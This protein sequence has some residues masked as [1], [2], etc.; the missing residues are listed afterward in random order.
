MFYG[1][2]QLTREI[3][4][5]RDGT[6]L[7]FGGRQLGKTALLRHVE[8]RVSDP[9]LRRFAW[10]IDLKDRGYVPDA[11]PAKDPGDILEVLRDRFRQDDILGDDTSGHSQEQMR[12]E[13]LDAFE[14]DRDLQVLAMFDESDAF[15]QSDWSSGSAVVE[16][17]RALM[18]NTGNRFK[19]VFAGLHNVQRF[20]NRPNNPFPNLGLQ[21]QQS[22]ERWDRPPQGPRGQKS[23]RATLQPVG[24]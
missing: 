15:L 23:R 4:A 2:E 10:F 9:G 19:V 7:I 17:L 5:M 18:D 3:V 16:S 13:I 24:I 12:Q 8:E 11:D 1:R 22:S 21:P 14:N 20:A 6:S